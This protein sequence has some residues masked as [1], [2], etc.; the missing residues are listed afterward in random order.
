V[1]GGR[2]GRRLKAGPLCTPVEKV[3]PMI[4]WREKFAS[5]VET[6][7][8]ALRRVR[9]G[10]RVFVSGNAAVPASLVEA[11][12]AR[13]DLED[14]EIVH[15]LTFG[16]APYTSPELQG[17]FRLNALFIGANTRAA[18]RDGRADYTPMHL[19]EIGKLFKR[20]TM[21]LDAALIQVSPPDEHGYCSYGVETN[22]VK[23]AAEGARIVIAEVNE[24][25]PRALG[26]CFIHMRDI[27]AVVPADRPLVEI[28]Q[29]ESDEISQKIARHIADL[30]EDGA[31]LQLGIGAIPDAVLTYLSARRDLGVHTEMFSDGI[32]P[33]IEQGVITNAKK[34]LHRQKIVA[35]FA[36]GTKKLYDFVHNNPMIEFRPS[37][38]VNDPFVIS[39]NDNLCAINSALEVDLTGQVCAESIG[40]MFYSG[41]GGQADFMRGAARSKNGKPII[42]L[43][44]T[45]RDGS[46]SRIVPT[47]K[48]GAGVTTTRAD[49]HYVVTEYGTAY[50]H[51]KSVR[52][53]A[54]ALIQIAHPKFRPWLLAAAKAQNFVYPDQIEPDIFA[55]VYPL[56]AERHVA[57]RDGSSVF[58]RPGQMTDEPLL[59]E[60]FYQL[61]DQ[62]I[63]QRFFQPLRSLPHA[64]LQQFLKVDYKNDMVLVATLGKHADAPIVGV[65]RYNRLRETDQA[66][67]AFVI[68]D[69]WQGKGLG[70][71]LFLEIIRLAKLN[72][73]RELVAE[74]LQENYGM[75]RVFHK[76]GHHVQSRLE[77]NI[78]HIT[79]DLERNA[80]RET[81][82]KTIEG[83]GGK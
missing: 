41:F 50:L 33:L 52:Q 38:Y 2:A 34:T 1:V 39:Q 70:T 67:V 48:E 75:L 79:I 73:I 26:D 43:P 24:Q 64:R 66:E 81:T 21:R 72:G 15:L 20:G 45:A 77:D 78:F 60:S 8:Q 80:E 82:P 19:H 57:L 3:F 51:G 9:N 68:S 59:R 53:R 5:K 76:G 27:D 4:A 31:T 54:L 32:L 49:V 42:A 83:A 17:R 10:D 74:V 65:A 58:I 44:S 46:I 25:M 11:L 36:F 61:S 30:V 62:A 12:V 63:Y 29:H 18:V 35:T 56:D 16:P 7:E 71:A 13:T 37:H 22:V 40:P 6:P 28:R 23:P 14:V 69:Q 47:L 55:P